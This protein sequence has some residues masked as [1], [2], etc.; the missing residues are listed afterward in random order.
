MIPSRATGPVAARCHSPYPGVTAS[1]RISTWPRC[2]CSRSSRWLCR[3]RWP[4]EHGS[5]SRVHCMLVRL[6]ALATGGISRLVG[7]RLVTPACGSAASPTVVTSSASQTAHATPRYEEYCIA[8]HADAMMVAPD[9]ALWFTEREQQPS[10][11]IKVIGCLTLSGRVTDYPVPEGSSLTSD[12]VA[13]PGWRAVVH[14]LQQRHRQNHDLG[15]RAKD[16]N[17]NECR[18]S[19]AHGRNRRSRVVYGRSQH[20]PRHT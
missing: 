7:A 19:R 14:R 17:R 5:L 11:N 18:N 12:I 16:R 6:F 2:H 1:V 4:T 15:R 13:G 20:R 9:G 10:A 3:P 8:T